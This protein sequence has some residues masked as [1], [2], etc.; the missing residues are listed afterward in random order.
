MIIGVVREG[1]KWAPDI[2][3]NVVCEFENKGKM[4]RVLAPYQEIHAVQ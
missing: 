4:Y 3:V 1:P 2:K